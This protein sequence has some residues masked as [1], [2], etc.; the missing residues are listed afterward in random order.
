MFNP[1]E[2]VFLVFYAHA[3]PDVALAGGK[4]QTTQKHLRETIRSL[5]K[6]LICV[7]IRLYHDADDGLNVIVRDL[8]L[9]EIA[10]AIYE[11]RSEEHT[12][13]LQSPCNLVCRL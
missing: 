8:W 5:G 7:P 11:H 4:P 9:K 1:R 6:H 10:H 13:E 3:P 12:S 2:A